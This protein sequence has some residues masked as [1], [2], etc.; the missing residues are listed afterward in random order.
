MKKGS[1]RLL[2]GMMLVLFSSIVFY[3][4]GPKDTDIN[5]AVDAKLKAIPDL[6]GV[7]AS[8]KDGVATIA[9]ECK[10]EATKTLAETTVK[11]VD[12]VKSVVNNC[13]VA[14]PPP[15]PAPVVI[16]QDDPLTK[17]V[18]DAIKDY[19]TVKAEVKDGVVTLTGELSRSSNKKLIQAIQQLHPKKVENKLTLK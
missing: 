7:T 3:S 19:P 14:P 1:L 6:A 13:T 17:S 2:T 8:V 5:A 4:C 12:H 16:A 11:G 9:G 10:D 18:N 15:A